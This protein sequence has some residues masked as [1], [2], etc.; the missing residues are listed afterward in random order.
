MRPKFAGN[1][2]LLS[3]MNRL[4]QL[5]WRRMQNRPKIP[6]TAVERRWLVFYLTGMTV[7]PYPGNY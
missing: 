7:F 2:V 3:F 5:L 1:P 6:N 4:Q